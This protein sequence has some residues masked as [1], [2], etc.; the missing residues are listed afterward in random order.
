MGLTYTLPHTK[1]TTNKD[2]LYSTGNS[3]Q[4]LVLIIT[5]NGRDH[6]KRIYIY[7]YIYI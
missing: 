4:Y 5:Y 1:Q 2:L 6:K 3:T 7:I